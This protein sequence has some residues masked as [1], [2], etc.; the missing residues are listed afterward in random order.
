MH[1]YFI[2][3]RICINNDDDD[4]HRNKI[5]DIFLESDNIRNTQYYNVWCKGDKC[6]HK[7]ATVK[8][9]LLVHSCG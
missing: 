9:V 1:T 6:K 8:I 3:R 5:S 2:N 4:E 7:A